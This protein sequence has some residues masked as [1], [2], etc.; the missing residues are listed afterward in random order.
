MITDGDIFFTSGFPFPLIFP[1]FNPVTYDGNLNRPCDTE[2]SR[3]AFLIKFDSIDAVSS[4]Q[5]FAKRVFL[6]NSNISSKV[7]ETVSYTHLTLPT[8]CSV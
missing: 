6:A 8:K 5:P 2:P 7:N 4:S 3:S 1:L